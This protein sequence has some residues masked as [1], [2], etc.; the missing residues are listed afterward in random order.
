[1]KTY[2]KGKVDSVLFLN[3]ATRHGGVLG[4]GGI[5]PRIFTRH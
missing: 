1:M 4:S 5:A 3:W 2:G